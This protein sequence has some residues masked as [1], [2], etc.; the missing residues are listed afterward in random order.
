MEDNEQQVL[1]EHTSFLD[2]LLDDPS[3]VDIPN[4]VRAA[5]E[6]EQHEDHEEEDEGIAENLNEDEVYEDS[7]PQPRK[8]RLSQSDRQKKQLAEARQHLYEMQQALEMERNKTLT[9]EEELF[10]A[11]MDNLE[12][13]EKYYKNISADY[14]SAL[15]SAYEDGASAAVADATDKLQDSKLYLKKIQEE[16]D[17]VFNLYKQYK[18]NPQQSMRVNL[19][20]D[21]SLNNFLERHPYLDPKDGNP[22]YSAE[23]FSEVAKISSDLS[24]QYKVQGRGD[25][26]R[27]DNYYND[28]EKIMKKNLNMGGKPS[29]PTKAPRS[30]R[31]VAPV[32]KR[33]HITNDEPDV[34]FT[35][36]DKIKM[37][38]L[39]NLFGKEHDDLL[40]RTFTTSKRGIPSMREDY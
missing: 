38:T 26:I 4:S 28:L 39:R 19:P 12:R 7:K 16:K 25:E 40:T 32:G 8:K 13:E 14:K 18:N 11:K 5:Q 29:T 22:N 9:Y 33:T 27:S 34:N 17:K 2:D 30:V 37:N 21:E 6:E 10:Q 1:D 36:S 23:A 20:V 31:M 24:K 3:L 35:R 15:E